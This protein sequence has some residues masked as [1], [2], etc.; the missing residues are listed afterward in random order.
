MQEAEGL[1]M[2]CTMMTAELNSVPSAL[3]MDGGDEWSTAGGGGREVLTVE[4]AA[5]AMAWGL[6]DVRRR[7]LFLCGQMGRVFIC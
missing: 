6:E 4:T 7:G 1:V 2:V 5:E 3:T